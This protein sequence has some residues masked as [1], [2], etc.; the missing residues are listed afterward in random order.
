M[1]RKL[2]RDN[3]VQSLARQ[4][5]LDQ[6]LKGKL[7]ECLVAVGDCTNP[8]AARFLYQVTAG[9][10]FSSRWFDC[11]LVACRLPEKVGGYQD[12]K[13]Y[14]L[15]PRSIQVLSA[16]EIRLGKANLIKSP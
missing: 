3:I 6:E 13:A 10:G 8:I 5:A 12:I 15:E 7:V 2:I 14:L 4:A 16:T 11:K 9:H 1:D